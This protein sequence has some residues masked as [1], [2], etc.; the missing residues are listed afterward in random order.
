MPQG[1]RLTPADSVSSTCSASHLILFLSLSEQ[2]EPK[3][4]LVI[5]PLKN[6]HY[7][8]CQQYL[9]YRTNQ[10]LPKREQLRAAGSCKAPLPVTMSGT[11]RQPD[12]GSGPRGQHERWR[13]SSGFGNARRWTCTYN[14]CLANFTGND[15]PSQHT[16]AWISFLSRGHGHAQTKSE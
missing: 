12:R 10:L 7:L 16:D 11:L 5:C 1:H 8:M 6:S 4:I 14:H 2:A 9:N 15:A 13:G 3:R